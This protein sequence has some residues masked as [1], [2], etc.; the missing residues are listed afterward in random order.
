MLG[1]LIAG[2]IFPC[3]LV[4]LFSRVTYNHIVGLLLTLALISVS[5]YKGYTHSWPLII[6]D[7]I[8][9]TIGFWYS[10]RMV[11]NFKRKKDE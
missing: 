2:L 1:K 8:S 7:G 6:I 5:A 11:K 9:L 10:K 4:I 3:L